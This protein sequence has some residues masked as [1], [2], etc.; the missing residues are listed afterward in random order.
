[1]IEER[2]VSFEIAR[3]LDTKDFD[4]IC[5]CYYSFNKKHSQLRHSNLSISKKVVWKMK[6]YAPHNR[7]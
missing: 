6:Y 2:Y 3:L 4:G 1:M 7:W 5:K